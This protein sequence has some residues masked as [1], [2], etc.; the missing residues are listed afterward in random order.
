LLAARLIISFNIIALIRI[1][2]YISSRNT[3]L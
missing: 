2:P 1:H 3:H